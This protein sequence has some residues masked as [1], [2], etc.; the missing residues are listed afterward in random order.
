[1]IPVRITGTDHRLSP[2]TRD[3][4]ARRFEALEGSCPDLSAVDLTVTHLPNDRAAIHV[5][6][7]RR[8]GP[9]LAVHATAAGTQAAL[10]AAAEKCRTRLHKLHDRRVRLKGA[11]GAV[12]G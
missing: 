7:H 10:D 5:V 12:A 3:Y 8:R 4:A 2:R 6:L 1:M 11:R 9:K